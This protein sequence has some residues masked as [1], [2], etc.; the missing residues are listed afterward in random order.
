RKHLSSTGGIAPRHIHRTPRHP[1]MLDGFS[2][3]RCSCTDRRGAKHQFIRKLTRQSSRRTQI[4]LTSEDRELLGM[5]P[6]AGHARR[7]SAV[8]QVLRAMVA[9]PEGSATWNLADQTSGG[10]QF[11]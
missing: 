2:E 4:M 1:Q 5:A 11:R 3:P 10:S 6:E 8:S 9:D 7:P